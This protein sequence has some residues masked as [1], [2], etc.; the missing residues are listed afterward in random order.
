MNIV[1]R[2]VQIDISK[3]VGDEMSKERT[4]LVHIYVKSPVIC[5]VLESAVPS[6]HSKKIQVPNMSQ[7]Q[8]KLKVRFMEDPRSRS[9]PCP[10][11]S[12]K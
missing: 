8:V 6:I 12:S 1:K 5:H 11:Y 7:T 10:Y 4:W 2:L 9:L 3:N